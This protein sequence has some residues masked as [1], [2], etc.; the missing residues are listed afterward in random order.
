M[1]RA[2]RMIE[3]EIEGRG[4]NLREIERENEIWR[5]RVENRKRDAER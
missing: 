5:V 1:R 3:G 2:E 4:N